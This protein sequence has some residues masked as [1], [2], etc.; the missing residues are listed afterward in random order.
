MPRPAMARIDVTAV[1]QMRVREG[2]S[3]PVLVRRHY[4]QMDA[5][6]HQAIA[7]N[8]RTRPRRGLGKQVAI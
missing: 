8:L 3:Q 5:I 2:A 4:Q 7:P 6:G 1:A